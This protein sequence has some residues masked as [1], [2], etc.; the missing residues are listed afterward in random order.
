MSFIIISYI[1]NI[2]VAGVMGSL[3]FFNLKGKLKERILKVFGENT[4]GRQI[5]ACLYLSIAIFSIIG[6]FNETYF[7]KI[8]L[9]LFPFQILYKT[10]TLISVKDKSNPVPY[11]NLAISILH[12]ISVY[13]IIQS[14]NLI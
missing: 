9:F 3:L 8:A 1:V 13:Q 7:F 12:M 5:L 14:G 11:F 4:S 6:L 10:L 2:L